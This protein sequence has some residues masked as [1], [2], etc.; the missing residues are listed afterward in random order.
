MCKEEHVKVRVLLI[1]WSAKGKDALNSDHHGSMSVEFSRELLK[2]YVTNGGPVD[3][4]RC[5]A[6]RERLFKDPD[7]PICV[8]DY[9]DPGNGKRLPSKIRDLSPE[10]VVLLGNKVQERIPAEEIRGLGHNVLEL[11]FPRIPN[12]AKN[13]ELLRDEGSL[14]DWVLPFLQ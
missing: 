6:A 4:P 5:K 11:G 1:G 7:H 3:P 13:V 9:E 2:A 10:L 12:Q 14:R 8:R